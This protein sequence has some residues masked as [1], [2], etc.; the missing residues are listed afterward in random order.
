MFGLP[1]TT[2]LIIVGIPLGWIA[3][4][5]IF[6]FSSSHWGAEDAEETPADTSGAGAGQMSSSSSAEA[7]RTPGVAA[8]EEGG[9]L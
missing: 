2:L 4:T 3:Y 9:A 6:F 8:P 1:V 5:L 7:G